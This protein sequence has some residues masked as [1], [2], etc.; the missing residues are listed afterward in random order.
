MN[1]TYKMKEFTD[2]DQ[3]QIDYVYNSDWKGKKNDRE[4]TSTDQVN[5]T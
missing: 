3:K 2:A 1:T 5:R 4:T